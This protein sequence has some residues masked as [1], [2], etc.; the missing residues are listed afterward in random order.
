MFLAAGS[1]GIVEK[2]VREEP[3]IWIEHKYTA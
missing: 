1:K 2:D 3:A